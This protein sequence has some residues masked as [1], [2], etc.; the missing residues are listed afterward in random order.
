M[1]NLGI[2]LFLSMVNDLLASGYSAK[3]IVRRGGEA[4]YRV[5]ALTFSF[6]DK[7]RL[8]PRWAGRGRE[9]TRACKPSRPP[10]QPSSVLCPPRLSYALFSVLAALRPSNRLLFLFRGISL[11]GRRWSVECLFSSDRYRDRHFT[12]NK[13]PLPRITNATLA[14]V[15]GET[16]KIEVR[17]EIQ[18]KGGGESSS[19][20][21]GLEVLS[22]S[23]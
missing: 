7:S 14:F 11:Q 16:V 4:R 19:F 5:K 15:I 10:V 20:L 21:A 18:R 12:L 2:L 17:G 3:S 13:A 6:I 8:S 22:T 23:C 9:T 1:Y